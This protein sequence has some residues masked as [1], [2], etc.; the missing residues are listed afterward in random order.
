[1]TSISSWNFH[2]ATTSTYFE[3]GIYEYLK[4]QNGVWMSIKW[5]KR[6]E[7]KLR[8]EEYVHFLQWKSNIE[9]ELELYINT[10]R[11]IWQALAVSESILDGAI[12]ELN[13][14]VESKNLQFMRH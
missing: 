6:N 12:G 14:C 11:V 2:V 10:T 9:F 7:I 13:D 3:I 1:M 4:W 5:T 8:V